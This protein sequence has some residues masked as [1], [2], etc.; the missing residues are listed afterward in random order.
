MTSMVYLEKKAWRNLLQQQE[1]R[2]RHFVHDLQTN[3]DLCYVAAEQLI[4]HK[5]YEK[6]SFDGIVLVTQT[7][8]YARPATAHVL[9]KR[10][11]LSKDC[12]AFDI[13]LGCSGFVYGVNIVRIDDSVRSIKKGSSLL[14]RI[15]DLSE[16]Y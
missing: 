5:G 14:R 12:M 6:D 16:S 7:P 11:R 3:S 4:S 15:A 2:E 8:D 13:N 1:L 10:L 9:H